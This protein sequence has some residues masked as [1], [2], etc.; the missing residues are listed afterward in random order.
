MGKITEVIKQVSQTSKEELAIIAMTKHH[1]SGN[2]EYMGKHHHS[3]S[4]TLRHDF[5]KIYLLS[6][7]TQFEVLPTASCYNHT[8]VESFVSAKKQIYLM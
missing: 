8:Q 4:K 2:C 1:F 7:Y 3:D 6:I 5:M